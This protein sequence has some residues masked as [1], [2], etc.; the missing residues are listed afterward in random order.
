MT[1]Y[2]PHCGTPGPDDARYCM[3][4]G[5]ERIPVPSAPP[6]PDAP[7]GPAVP[8]TPPTTPPTEPASAPSGAP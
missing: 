6:A 5:R 8:P 1:S 2:C 3:K 7:A 4:C